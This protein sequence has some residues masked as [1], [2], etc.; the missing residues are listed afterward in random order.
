MSQ[1]QCSRKSSFKTLHFNQPQLRLRTTEVRVYFCSALYLRLS[2][3]GIHPAFTQ[4]SPKTHPRLSHSIHTGRTR[5]DPKPY[6]PS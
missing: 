1:N 6:L 4:H 2:K 5:L 3:I